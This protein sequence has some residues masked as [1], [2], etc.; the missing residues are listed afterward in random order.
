VKLTAA[1]LVA[2]LA[3]AP[4]TEARLQGIILNRLQLLR[5]H[6]FPV[7]AW[8]A[9]SGVGRGANGRAVRF[10]E[11]G[12]SDI[13]AVV[14]GKFVAIEVKSETG[15][16]SSAQSTWAVSIADAGGTY[17]LARSLADALRPVLALLES[18]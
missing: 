18:T 17:V 1:A 11:P 16:M 12:Q 15:R 2:P 9:N 4:T 6:G 7:R 3:H 8:R 14:A 13:M 10:G 5:A